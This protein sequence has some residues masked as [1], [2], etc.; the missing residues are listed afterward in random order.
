[1]IYDA[2]LVLLGD[3]PPMSDAQLAVAFANIVAVPRSGLEAFLNP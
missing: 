1:M 3:E 2:G